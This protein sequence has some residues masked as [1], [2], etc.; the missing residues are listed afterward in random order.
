MKTRSRLV[1]A[2]IAATSALVATGLVMAQNAAPPS[3]ATPAAQAP[4]AARSPE[5]L[6]VAFH[7]DWC[8][9]CQALGPKVMNDV[10]PE[11]G[12]EP[13]LLVSLD[14][15]D[16]GSDQAEYMLSALGLG[17]LWR[18]YGRKTGFI[19]MVDAESK[20]VLQTFRPS[21]DAG[22]MVGQIKAACKG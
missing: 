18:T 14:L 13:Y 6:L 20:R 21:T 12:K 1:F 8:S 16:Q 3:R 4:A 17:E 11:L 5:V 15:T 19:A 7:A 10:L 9:A 22:E 2:A